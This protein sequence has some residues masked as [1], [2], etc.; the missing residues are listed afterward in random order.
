[1]KGKGIEVSKRG[2]ISDLQLVSLFYEKYQVND[3][4]LA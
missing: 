2:K 1:M 4:S 3:M